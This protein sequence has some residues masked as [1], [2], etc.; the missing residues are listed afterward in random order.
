MKVREFCS[1]E[2][3][4][5]EPLASLREASIVMRNKHVGALVVV[6]R[7]NDGSRPVGIITDRDIIVAVIAVPGARPEGIRVCDAMSTRLAVA[8]EDDGVFEAVQ[9]MSER[10][11]RRL[12]VV[13][14]K[15]ALCGI[16]TADDVQRVVSTEMANLA[17]ALKK[18]KE[19]EVVERRIL[20]V[21]S[22]RS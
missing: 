8:R 20:D 17:T 7:E 16:V 21:L 1:K 4:T 22:S 10:G 9:T 3:V 19:R 12:P 6:E 14:A 15:G 5:V 18:G 11:V 2:V 13:D